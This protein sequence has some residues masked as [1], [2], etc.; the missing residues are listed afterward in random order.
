MLGPHH[1]GA[2]DATRAT[3]P[4]T[5][6]TLKALFTQ[7]SGVFFLSSAVAPRTHLLCRPSTNLLTRTV[8]KLFL[9]TVFLPL[10]PANH[11][12]PSTLPG[13]SSAD[14]C[15]SS[16][17]SRL[18]AGWGI[19]RRASSRGGGSRFSGGTSPRASTRRRARPR[20]ATC[21]GLVPRAPWGAPHARATLLQ[22][23]P[24]PFLSLSQVQRGAQSGGTRALTRQPLGGGGEKML[25]FVCLGVGGSGRSPKC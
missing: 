20:T 17:L 19:F 25:F 22:P 15:A 7:P 12:F 9:L 5:V 2:L 16:P 1:C 21:A 24:S 3:F 13:R 6:S 14:S 10:S 8:R 18:P 11:V 4:S 23:S